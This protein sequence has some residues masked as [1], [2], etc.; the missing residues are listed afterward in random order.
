M[1]TGTILS[2]NDPRGDTWIPLGQLCLKRLPSPSRNLAVCCVGG[3]QRDAIFTYAKDR[4]RHKL[5]ALMPLV[6]LQSQNHHF[7]SK[8]FVIFHSSTALLTPMP[9]LNLMPHR[10]TRLCVKEAHD[11]ARDLVLQTLQMFQTHN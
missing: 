6:S 8:E 9:G 10:P 2:P 11:V 5:I 3:I 1:L 7:H 4:S